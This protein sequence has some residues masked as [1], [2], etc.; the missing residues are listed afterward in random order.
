M[1]TFF[2]Q[3]EFF[4]ILIIQAV[5]SIFSLIFILKFLKDTSLFYENISSEIRKIHTQ[6]T[7][8][9]G[10]IIFL[11]I[12]I[13]MFHIQNGQLKGAIFIAIVFLFI[14]IFADTIKNFSWKLRLVLMFIL[15]LFTIVN[16][17]LFVID[18]YISPLNYLLNFYLFSIIFTSLC[19]LI[20][21]NG[22]NFID[23]QHGLATG[24]S[25]IIF[26]SFYMNLENDLVEIKLLIQ[27]L[28]MI[29]FILFFFNFVLN[30]IFIGDCG[31]YFLG[32]IISI[33]AIKINIQHS[34]NPIFIACILSYPMIELSVTF[35]RRVFI[36]KSNPFV[37]DQLHLHSIMYRY[38]INKNM[39][40]G[41]TGDFHNKLTSLI[42]IF[43][44]SIIQLVAYFYGSQIGY[45]SLFLLI[46]LCYMTVYSFLL[47]RINKE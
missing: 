37:P 2:M 12:P 6:P 27:S 45:L 35:L 40:K 43:S 41:K 29:C 4:I 44:Y 10:G 25:I 1:I 17:N 3:I 14:G 24:I 9:I 42:I 32:F 18:T 39:I 33:I 21:V 31:S 26:L 13:S 47:I 8:K 11:F 46:F 15:T 30:R 16:F 5:L 38:L 7:F 22:I 36:N 20:M 19:F 34:I 23:G 28:I